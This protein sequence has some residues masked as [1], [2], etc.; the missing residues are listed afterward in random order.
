MKTLLFAGIV[1]SL[2]GCAQ[3]SGGADSAGSVHFD[4]LS[5]PANCSFI[6]SGPH[7][8]LEWHG[9]SADTY[10]CPDVTGMTCTLALD[11][12]EGHREMVCVPNGSP[13]MPS[14][15]VAYAQGDH[16][17]IDNFEGATN[18]F[19]CGVWHNNLRC[20]YF[21]SFNNAHAEMRCLDTDLPF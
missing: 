21:Q 11:S 3:G 5:A 12:A 19:D 18:A 14:Q 1:L 16:E 8:F 6:A 7:D 2:I 15:C 13:A 17:F 4:S 10:S 9:F 20:F